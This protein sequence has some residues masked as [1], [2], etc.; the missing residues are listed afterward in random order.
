MYLTESFKVVLEEYET[1]PI[2]YDETV[3]DK[4]QIFAMELWRLR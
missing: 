1:K 4:M 3:G 2:D